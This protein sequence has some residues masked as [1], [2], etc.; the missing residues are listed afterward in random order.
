MQIKSGCCDEVLIETTGS[1]A[2]WTAHLARAD[3]DVRSECPNC[4]SVRKLVGG[5]SIT[6]EACDDWED[7]L[8]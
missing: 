1:V 2:A 5:A 8:P 6:D 3:V 4:G 7:G